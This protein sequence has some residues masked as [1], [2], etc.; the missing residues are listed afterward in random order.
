MNS[1]W[2]DEVLKENEYQDEELMTETL[3]EAKR[4]QY[5]KSDILCM[6]VGE[7]YKTDN[8]LLS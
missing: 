2:D 6:L 3:S 4:S 1:Q 7:T 8:L 5:L